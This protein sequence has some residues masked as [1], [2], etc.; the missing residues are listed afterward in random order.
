MFTTKYNFMW[1]M[2]GEIFSETRNQDPQSLP[3]AH[4]FP[5]FSKSPENAAFRL[6]LK[7]G[8]CAFAVL[9][10]IFCSGG[11]EMKF[12][13]AVIAFWLAACSTLNTALVQPTV[14]LKS[15]KVANATLA[16]ATL[17]F[18]FQVQNPNEIAISVDRIKYALSVN[19]QPL[20]NGILDQ[21]LKVNGKSLI[22]VPL[23]VPIKYTDL[24]SSLATFLGQEITPY[25]ITGDVQAGF[26]T[27]PFQQK[28]DLKL[29]DLRK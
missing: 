7:D 15:V 25:E 28:G 18:N 5:G 14:D 4:L 11:F 24:G 16:D 9:A 22:N 17:I 23:P 19:G 12:F 10:L 6:T 26:L 2:E 27:I 13:S 21:G 1:Q 20:T 3:F 8:T 29:S